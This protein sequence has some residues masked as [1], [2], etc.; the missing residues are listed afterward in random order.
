MNN[1]ETS[2]VGRHG[3]IGV[4]VFSHDL[5]VE[6]LPPDV[7]ALIRQVEAIGGRAL[8]ASATDTSGTEPTVPQP[9]N[10]YTGNYL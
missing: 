6:V 4:E 8:L 3:S 7:Q 5:R 9:V 1:L 2:P 10:T